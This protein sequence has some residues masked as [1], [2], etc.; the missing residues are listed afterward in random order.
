MENINVF[1]E[2]QELELVDYL[3]SM[4]KRLWFDNVRFS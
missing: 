2:Q 4:E 1:N 3:K